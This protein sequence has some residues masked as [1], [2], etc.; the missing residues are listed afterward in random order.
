MNL[1]TQ[2]DT[3][4]RFETNLESSCAKYGLDSGALHRYVKHGIQP[5]GFLTAVLSNDFMGAAGRADSHNKTR[6]NEWAMVVYNDIPSG[7]HGS[8]ERV[9]D[10]VR[11]GGL[12]GMAA[13]NKDAASAEQVPDEDTP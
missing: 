8:R 4:N 12:I 13:R 6:L 3:P 5:G 2:S 1:T 7:C 11:A 10:W 9:E